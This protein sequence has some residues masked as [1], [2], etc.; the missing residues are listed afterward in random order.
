MSDPKKNLFET[1]K[2]V[3]MTNRKTPPHFST[4]SS[5]QPVVLSTVK[6]CKSPA[7]VLRL[8]SGMIQEKLLL[9]DSNTTTLNSQLKFYFDEVGIDTESSSA[10]MKEKSLWPLPSDIGDK[11]NATNLLK[12]PILLTL[13]EL[14]EYVGRVRESGR[15]LRLGVTYKSMAKWAKANENPGRNDAQSPSH[16]TSTT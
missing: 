14:V 4:F 6:V 12:T 11:N 8:V 3:P 10:L 2:K 13:C 16:S 7:E 1:L 15:F 9:E 5:T